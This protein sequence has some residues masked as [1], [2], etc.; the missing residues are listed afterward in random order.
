VSGFTPH[1]EYLHDIDILMVYLRD[2]EV[3]TTRE[4]ANVWT[5]VDLDDNGNIVE[6][7]FVN[8]AGVGVDLSTIPERETVERLIREANILRPVR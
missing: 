2:G 7:E 3:A 1:A 8:A 6:I 4:G 5:N